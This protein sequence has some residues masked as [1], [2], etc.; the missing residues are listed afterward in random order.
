M[1]KNTNAQWN[2]ENTIE[3]KNLNLWSKGGFGFSL[4]F[5]G[6]YKFNLGV[7]LYVSKLK[8]RKSWCV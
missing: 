8:T 2:N 3:A 6:N 4:R 1:I 7:I 5:F